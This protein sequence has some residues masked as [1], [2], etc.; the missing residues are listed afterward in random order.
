MN[1]LDEYI[2]IIS[3]V[4]DAPELFTKASAYSL[5]SNL[6]GRY[7]VGYDMPHGRPNLWFL[8]SSIPGR[9]RRSTLAS[10]YDTA[11]TEALKRYTQIKLGKNSEGKF[12]ELPLEEIQLV[13]KTR[14]M[15]GT[16]EGISDA[17]SQRYEKGADVFNIFS[18]EFGGVLKRMKEVRYLSG[19]LNLLSMLYYGEGGEI[20][21]SKRSGGTSRVIPEDLY[22]TMFA[23]MQEPYLYLDPSMIRQGTM[24]R[25]LLIY[26][27][28]GNMERW[29]QP[30][31]TGFDEAYKEIA[32]WGQ[33][34]AELMVKYEE[35]RENYRYSYYKRY[36]HLHLIFIST[37]S[38]KINTLARQLDEAIDRVQTDEN[39][40]KQSYWEHLA[41]LSMINS[42]ADGVFKE[43]FE[44]MPQMLVN[45][46]HF[47]KAEEFLKQIEAK[48]EGVIDGLGEQKKSMVS[49]QTPLERVYGIV[50]KY[51]RIKKSDIH[52]HLPNWIKKD[53]GSLL[54]TLVAQERIMY[55]RIKPAVGRPKD[56]YWIPV[57]Y[58][59]TKPT[60]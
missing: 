27:K 56:V 8:I 38:D 13:K 6:L 39:I 10:Y 55:E 23:G 2:E 4:C 45:N 51:R 34:V 22:V 52:R 19:T 15:E 29:L 7:F 1:I 42:I 21:L 24:R 25:I 41:K 57:N 5:I 20:L 54:E 26:E 58:E 43:G 60:T 35:M 28:K 46:S 59:P 47:V 18:S 32:V 53:V 48:M 30:L 14:I 11:Y 50:A 3:E 9:F 17:I 16:P 31:R 40:Y 12:D 49:Y 33:K 44:G 36:S 37:I